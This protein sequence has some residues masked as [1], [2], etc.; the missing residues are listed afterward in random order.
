MTEMIDPTGP[1]VLELRAAAATWPA[2]LTNYQIDPGQVAPEHIPKDGSAPLV[3][4]VRRGP[5]SR[6]RRVPLADFM[7][8]IDCY[9]PDQEVT[10]KLSGLVSDAFHERGPRMAG[11]SG[12]R[13]G[14]FQSVDVGQSGS[15]VE[16]GTGWPV[17]RVSVQLTAATQVLA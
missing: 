1:V 16:P 14:L 2:P 11:A 12:N 9:H 6:R 8:T 3:V 5:P 17:E 15:L 13:R 7:F 10:A 4:V